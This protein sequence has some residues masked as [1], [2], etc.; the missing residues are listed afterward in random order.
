VA[1]SPAT[2]GDA[3]TQPSTTGDR[4]RRRSGGIGKWVVLELCPICRDRLMGARLRDR[5][6]TCGACGCRSLAVEMEY[7]V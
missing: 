1:V 6:V 7:D 3:R 2:R 5:I 4:H